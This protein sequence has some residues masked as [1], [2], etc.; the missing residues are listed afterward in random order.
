VIGVLYGESHVERYS[1]IVS[2]MLDMGIQEFEVM[3]YAPLRC[4]AVAI[5]DIFLN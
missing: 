4:T 1:E 3:H 5:E 2:Y